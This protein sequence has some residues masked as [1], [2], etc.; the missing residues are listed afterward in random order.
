M[1]ARAG[2]LR[3]KEERRGTVRDPLHNRPVHWRS[4]IGVRGHVE[5]FSLGRGQQHI[6]RIAVGIVGIR[7]C[8]SHFN[9]VERLVQRLGGGLLAVVQDLAPVCKIPAVLQLHKIVGPVIRFLDLSVCET[10]EHEF[11]HVPV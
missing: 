6:E 11:A 7:D 2:L 10:I 4:V 8:E 3:R 1:S 5:E 9:V